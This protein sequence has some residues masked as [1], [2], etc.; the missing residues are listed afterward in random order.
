MSTPEL[1]SKQAAYFDGFIDLCVVHGVDPDALMKSGQA[2][3][4]APIYGGTP[5]P[6]TPPAAGPR[7]GAGVLEKLLGKLTDKYYGVPKATEAAPG[8][9]AIPSAIAAKSRWNKDP[10]VQVA[11]GPDVE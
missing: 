11:G 9:G 5:V 3:G 1:D 4:Q 6:R 10:S 2:Y 8:M 7:L